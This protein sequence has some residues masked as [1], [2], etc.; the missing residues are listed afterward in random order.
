MDEKFINNI[1][2]T[3]KQIIEEAGSH[4]PQV[5]FEGRKGGFDTLVFDFSNELEKNIALMTIRSKLETGKYKSVLFIMEAWMISRPN[6]EINERP[7]QAKDK[8]EIL[9]L[10]YKEDDGNGKGIVLPF[11]REGKKIIWK[12]EIISDKIKG[13]FWEVW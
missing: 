2:E 10:V 3:A 8:K 11:K 9:S 5:F 6:E 12:K 13:K 1:K 4:K 7:S